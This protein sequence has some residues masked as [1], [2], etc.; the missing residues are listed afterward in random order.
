MSLNRIPEAKRKKQ[1]KGKVLP[2]SIVLLVG[3]YQLVSALAMTILFD[4]L[5][6]IS[7]IT[8]FLFTLTGYRIMVGKEPLKKETKKQETPAGT[9]RFHPQAEEERWKTSTQKAVQSRQSFSARGD[10]HQHI[11]V[12]GITKEKQL[13]QLQVLM[14]AGLY[15]KEEYRAEKEKILSRR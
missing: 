10:N 4:R 13:E 6:V 5:D 3:L 7:L 1:G 8:S 2:G 11:L 9:S 12:T 14:E 15:T